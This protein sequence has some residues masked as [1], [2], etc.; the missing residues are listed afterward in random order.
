MNKDV[1]VK[2]ESIIRSEQGSED[3]K[4]KARGAYFKKDE[5]LY[6][7]YDEKNEEEVI[8]KCRLKVYTDRL[9]MK[10]S[11]PYTTG[12]TFT[13]D[14]ITKCHYKTPFGALDL[15]IETTGYDLVIDERDI[16]LKLKYRLLSGKA[17][18]S[19]HIMNISVTDREE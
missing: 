17:V 18:M 9:E 19:E 11:G 7:L 5:C 2:I 1:T 16:K 8:N 6:I 4:S 14:E 12:M 10:K 15:E 13:R 3:I